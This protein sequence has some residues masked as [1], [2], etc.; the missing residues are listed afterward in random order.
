MRTWFAI[1]SAWLLI[2]GC[3][4][5]PRTTPEAV[6]LAVRRHTDVG[7]NHV[8][9]MGTRRGDHYLLHQHAWG[10]RVYR[11]DASEVVIDPVFP[12]TRDPHAWRLLTERWWPESVEGRPLVFREQASSPGGDLGTVRI[13]PVQDED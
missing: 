7:L 1:V 5:R 8:F 10:S 3:A 11:L 2:S 12:Y 9:Y 6:G 13:R 4:T